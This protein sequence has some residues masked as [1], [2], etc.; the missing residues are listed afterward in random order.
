MGKFE[1]ENNKGVIVSS[2]FPVVKGHI[3][4]EEYHEAIKK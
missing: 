2:N 1:R 4:K 3:T